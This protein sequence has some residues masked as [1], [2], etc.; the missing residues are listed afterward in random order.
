MSSPENT[1]VLEYMPSYTGVN[2]WAGEN[3][4]QMGV[5]SE[6]HIHPG[7]NNDAVLVYKVPATGNVT[8]SFPGGVSV[9]DSSWADRPG[10]G[11]TF[12]VFYRDDTAVHTLLPMTDIGN[13]ETYT[14]SAIT[15][16]VRAGGLLLFR[17]G[18]GHDHYMDY[19][20]TYMRSQN[21]SFR[22]RPEKNTL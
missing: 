11:V 1:D 4:Y 19:D 21:H 8:V 3:N 16:D 5:H 22:P 2:W 17:C 12:G 10:D 20:N 13:G 9:N 14:P 15:V 7:L 18:N 6:D